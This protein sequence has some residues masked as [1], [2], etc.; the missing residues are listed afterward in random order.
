MKYVVLAVL[1]LLLGLLVLTFKP[2]DP[3]LIPIVRMR[4]P[5]GFFVTYVHDRV[6]GGK[7]CQ[8]EI[9]VYVE[10]L[11]AACPDCNIE[12]T[13]CA[14]ELV[15]MEKAL[16]EKRP[17]PVYVVGAEGVRMSVVGPP[18]KVQIWCEVV[19]TQIVRNGLKSASCIY[20]KGAS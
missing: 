13:A 10:P 19:A 7:A 9:R 18:K 8:E 4:S 14:G 3:M 11:Q 16:V 17:L 2:E 1:M 15:G 5:E 20:P 12:S 6:K